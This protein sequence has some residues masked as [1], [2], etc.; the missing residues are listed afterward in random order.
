M[1]FK[2]EY[3]AT[4]SRPAYVFARQMGDGNFTISLLPRLDNV[5]IRRD[6]SR[7]RALTANGEPDFKV[8]T[9]TLV[10]ANDLPKLKI[11]QIVE[12]T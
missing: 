3:I 6:F 1:K 7:P 12:L 10:T 4:K 5:P 2:I 8:F 9:F 11:G